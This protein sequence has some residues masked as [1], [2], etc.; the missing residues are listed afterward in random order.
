MQS[1]QRRRA[2]ILSLGVGL[3]ALIASVF[4]FAPNQIA[5]ASGHCVN[6]YLGDK[7]L[8]VDSCDSMWADYFAVSSPVRDSMKS[9]EDWERPYCEKQ[10]DGPVKHYTFFEVT[11]VEHIACLGI[12][13]H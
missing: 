4:L 1:P 11:G 13:M 5:S 2:A 7:Y 12:A 6:K 10:L 9:T 8:V 3:A